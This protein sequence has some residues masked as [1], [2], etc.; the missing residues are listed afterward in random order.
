MPVRT[1]PFKEMPHADSLPN[2]GNT[3]LK[4]VNKRVNVH[5]KHKPNNNLSARQA[6]F[7]SM[8]SSPKGEMKQRHAIENGGFHMPGSNKK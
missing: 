7:N 3:P 2:G 6:D 8:K 1:N 5:G 4:K